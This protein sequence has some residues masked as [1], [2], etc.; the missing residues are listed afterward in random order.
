MKGVYAM[1][2]ALL[3]LDSR[4]CN[5]VFPVRLSKVK[6]VDLVTPP[7]EILDNFIIAALFKDIEVWVREQAEICEI[8]VLSV[9]ML[10]YGGLLASR[11]EV[12]DIAECKRRLKVI[13]NIKAT[14][15][16]LRI[17]A[18]NVIMRT[19]ISVLDDE[20][21]IWWEKINEYSRLTHKVELENISWD[22]E[23]L[24]K[25]TVDIPKEILEGFLKTRRRNHVINNACVDL[26]W[27]GVIDQLVLLQEDSHKYGIHRKEQ[28]L[29]NQR[30]EACM[31]NTRIQMHNGTDE[32]GCLLVARAINGYFNNT[33]A[34]GFEYL[35]DSRKNFIAKY[36]DRLFHENLISHAETCGIMLK[37]SLENIDIALFIHT[38][39]R[40]QCDVCLNEG[41]LQSSYSEKELVGFAQRIADAVYSGKKVGLLD[42]VYANGGDGRLLYA[43]SKKINLLD[44]SGYAAW[45]TASNS[46]GTILAQ[47]SLYALAEPEKNVKFTAERLL[48]DYLYQSVVRRKLE[49]V[50][51]ERGLDIWNLKD[52]KSTADTLLAEYFRKSEELAWMFPEKRVVFSSK[53]A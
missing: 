42:I 53:L 30:I 23:E 26:V 11:R 12:P 47:L 35:A 25:L 15:P 13:N 48:D 17:Y 44:L 7:V 2:I 8:L 49:K 28:E 22:K 20:S 31:L 24:A 3:S 36:E 52:G 34:I 9:D 38:P 4:P 51:K 21:R 41:E 46:L 43:L 6:D 40:E 16:T 50:L 29:L 32:A 45:N 1:R 27:E 14:N 19:S 10:I 39:K 5:R 33:I 18:F 37:N